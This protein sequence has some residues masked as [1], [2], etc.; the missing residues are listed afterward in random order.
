MNAGLRVGFIG[1]G[2]QG[3]PMARAIIDRGFPTSLWARRPESVAPFEGAADIVGSPAVLANA[4]DLVGICVLTDDDVERVVLGPNG[5]IEGVRPGTIVAIHSTVHPGTCTRIATAL[6]A[7]GA[8][9]LDAPVSGGGLAAAAHQLLVMVGGDPIAFNRAKPVFAAFGD[10]IV[11]VG[12]LGTG[13][14][15]K[16]VNNLLLTGTLSLVHHAVDLGRTF[17]IEPN[18]LLA[19]LQR[20]SSRS[21]A[22]DMYTGMRPGLGDP[23]SS[24]SGIAAL[25][26][27]DVRLV[28]RLIA[29]SGGDG[30][31]LTAAADD[32]LRAMVGSHESQSEKRP[33]PPGG[34]APSK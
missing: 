27:K 16:L 7:A 2:S 17:G 34:P 6:A 32:I 18:A 29:E 23:G 11:H 33:T 8:E 26:G 28:E 19:C 9:V 10:P 15:A 20:G 31:L 1:L 22:L 14:M 3:G 13:Q 25:L 24:V 21:F 12:P 4:V 30:A 5:L